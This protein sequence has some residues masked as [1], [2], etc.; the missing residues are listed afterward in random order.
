MKSD[1]VKILEALSKLFHD[2]GETPIGDAIDAA[3]A[4]AADAADPGPAQIRAFADRIE[5]QTGLA[6]AV[7]AATKAALPLL[8]DGPEKDALLAALTAL[9]TGSP[10]SAPEPRGS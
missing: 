2:F 9:D 7:F 1:Q 8:P 6:Q 5:E 4:E 3:A 10:D